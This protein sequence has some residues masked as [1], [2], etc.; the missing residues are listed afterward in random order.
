MTDCYDIKD[1]YYFSSK[2]AKHMPENPT[3]RIYNKIGENI[4]QV[5]KGHEKEKSIE[6]SCPSQ[7]ILDG[8]VIGNVLGEG[9]SGSIIAGGK[10]IDSQKEVAIKIISKKDKTIAQIDEIRDQIK[11]YQLAG[12]CQYVVSMEDY[13]ENRDYFYLCL[14]LLSEQNLFEYIRNQ[15][16]ILEERRARD[17]IM[18][19][20]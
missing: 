6:Q 4:L 8:E 7:L 20:G 16:S 1:H 18:K 3:S 10:H 13:F 19:I 11:M 17:L 14:E 12:M 9:R 15:A 2:P 5:I